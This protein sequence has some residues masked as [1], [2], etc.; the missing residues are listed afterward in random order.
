MNAGSCCFI[1]SLKAL[2]PCM[3]NTEEKS[4]I[5]V[6]AWDGII[7]IHSNEKN[8][9]FYYLVM[10]AAISNE[11]EMLLNFILLSYHIFP[12]ELNVVKMLF[13]KRLQKL[14]HEGFKEST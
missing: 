10:A 2:S 12:A 14:W 13:V 6:P 7:G 5:I 3:T 1:P 8:F 11:R 9:V 4:N